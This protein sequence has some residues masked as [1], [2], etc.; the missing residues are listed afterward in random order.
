MIGS[1]SIGC[2]SKHIHHAKLYEA[3]LYSYLQ[4]DFGTRASPVTKIASAGNAKPNA[5]IANPSLP[6]C[7]PS[8]WAVFSYLLNSCALFS[9]ELLSLARLFSSL[10]SLYLRIV[11][12]GRYGYSVIVCT[13][14]LLSLFTVFLILYAD[15]L[16]LF[17]R[18]LTALPQLRAFFVPHRLPE[19]EK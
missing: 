17:Y 14:S 9:C 4:Q 13:G 18:F 6:S 16:P 10:W 2:R 19:F 15:L 7:M 8:S 5:W 12:D 11:L 1:S 3:I